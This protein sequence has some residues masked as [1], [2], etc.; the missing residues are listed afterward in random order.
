MA[1]ELRLIRREDPWYSEAE[2]LYDD[3]FPP[4]E[5][6]PFSALFTEFGGAEELLAV[7]DGDRFAGLAVLLTYQDIT[8]ILYLAVEEGLRGCG[9]GSRILALI[10]ERY[11]GQKIIADLELPEADTPNEV[12]REKRIAFY[13]KN[14][15][16]LTGIVYR[17]EGE[18]Y[19]IMASGGTVTREAFGKFWHHFYFGR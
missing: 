1:P 2:R 4:N 9:Y 5:R 19:C 14:G 17:W 13:R 18:D 6:P 3:S 11:P 15:Y 8:H 12:Q 10:R 16:C 7:L